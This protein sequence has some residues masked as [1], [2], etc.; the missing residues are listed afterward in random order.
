M[1]SLEFKKNKDK[2]EVNLFSSKNSKSFYRNIIDK[3]PGKL[4]QILIDLHLYNY[5]VDKAIKI[6]LKRVKT[7]DW[8]GL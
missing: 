8:L 7:H 6:F 2:F 3:D 5:P 1:G 4:A